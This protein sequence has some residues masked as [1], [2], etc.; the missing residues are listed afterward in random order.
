MRN[1]F[2]A[3][4]ASAL[5]LAPALADDC[6]L[7]RYA[8]IP[9]ETDE[10][11]QIYI[12]STIDGRP[13]LVMLDTGAYWSMVSRTYAEANNL[14]IGNSLF[15]G[16][17]DV[18]GEAMDKMTSGDFKMGGVSY[19]KSEFFIGGLSG[20]ID[21]LIGQNLLAKVDL[22]ID[23]ANKVI[24]LF[25]QEHCV[26]DGVYWADE[27]VT[28]KYKRQTRAPIGS[29]IRKTDANQI[30]MPIVGAELDGKPVTM[31]FDT[32]ATFTVMDLEYAKRRYN[33]T[34]ETPGVKPAG[35]LVGANGG[36]SDSYSYTFSTLTIAG[37]KFENVP[38]RLSKLENKEMLLGMHELRHLRLYFASKDGMI[39]VT[40]ADAKRGQ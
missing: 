22:E 14:R 31:L 27:A 3:L 10:T 33:L 26:G 35:R 9:F 4:T 40:A 37:I 8:A 34:P 21:G 36:G 1:L 23:N 12:R 5:C 18:N 32:G 11:S 6:K 7:S 13:A 28:L 25:S 24:S 30:D 20:D 15:L 17:R 39:H 29:N 16:L 2:F 19:G 38:I